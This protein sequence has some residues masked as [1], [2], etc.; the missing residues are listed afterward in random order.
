MMLVHFQNYGH[1]P[2]ILAG[3]ATGMI[4]DPS[5]KSKE[6]QLLTQDIIVENIKGQKADFERVLD[7]KKAGNPVEMVNNYDWF[8]DFSLLDFMRDVGK[9]LT[10]SYM[11]AKDSV[12]SRMEAGISFTEF[13]YQLIQGYDFYYLWKNKNCKVQ[14]GGSD[15][16][17]NITAGTELIRRIGGGAAFALTCPLI[18]KSDGT[19]IGKSES[20]AIFLNPERTSPYTFYQ[21]WLNVSD[22]DAA[23]FIKLFTLLD[24]EIIEKMIAEH[25]QDPG[26]RAL[27]KD[28][29]R[30]VTIMIHGEEEYH[31]ALATSEVLFGKP[32]KQSLEAIATDDMLDVFAGVPTFELDRAAHG[33]GL[34]IVDFLAD[35]TGILKSKGEARRSLKENSISINTEKVNDTKQISSADL[36]HDRFILVQRGKKNKFLVVVS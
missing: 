10:V 29:A 15:Q 5:G 16:W 32:T 20:G 22:E 25:E 30:L 4:G 1:N 11:I 26:Q 28:L 2:I 17:G 6:R 14:F 34:P 13:S 33:D 3:G 18:T 27:Q 9:H 24:K 7:F 8:K 19:K 12:K 31:K 21:Y 23:K 36:I 35:H